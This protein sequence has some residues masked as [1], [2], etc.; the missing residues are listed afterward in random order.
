ME[1]HATMAPVGTLLFAIGTLGIAAGFGWTTYSA[2]EQIRETDT[3]ANDMISPASPPAPPAH[4]SPHP[5][6]PPEAP[7]ARRLFEQGSAYKF[8]P[9]EEQKIMRDVRASLLGVPKSR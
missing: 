4:P 7:T 1:A 2:L 9:N 5:P 3:R 8:N 6:P